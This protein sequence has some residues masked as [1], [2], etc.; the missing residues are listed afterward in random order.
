MWPAIVIAREP[1][2]RWTALL[3]VLLV[4]AAIG[5]APTGARWR[6]GLAAGTALSVL[7]IAA[8]TLYPTATCGPPSFGLCARA[9]AGAPGEAVPHT[10]EGIL[11]VLLFVP[12]GI[13]LTLTWRRVVLRW[14]GWACSRRWSN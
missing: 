8:V 1:L 9:L 2:V 5:L 11:N 14:P 10:G 13:G 7:L 3:G 4:L 6:R 12:A